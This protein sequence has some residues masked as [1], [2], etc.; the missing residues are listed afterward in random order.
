MYTYT[1]THFHG[2]KK[3]IKS[4]LLLHETENDALFI[5]L[6]A[7]VQICI[8]LFPLGAK[9]MLNIAQTH[10]LCLPGCHG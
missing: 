10:G 9:K 4:T 3:I 7:P 8:D 6:L 1:Y 2:E 5:Y